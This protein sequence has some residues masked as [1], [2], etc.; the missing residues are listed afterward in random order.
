MKNKF[1]RAVTAVAL[2]VIMLCTSAPVYAQTDAAQVAAGKVCRIGDV[3][4]STI[5]EAVSAVEKNGTATIT[6]IANDKIETGKEDGS[7]THLKIEKACNITIEGNNHTLTFENGGIIPTVTGVTLTVNNLNIH[8]EFKTGIQSMVQGRNGATLT[9]NNCNFTSASDAGKWVVEK[10]GKP[11]DYKLFQINNSGAKATNMIFNGGSI[12]CALTHTSSSN[13]WLMMFRDATQKGSV[14]F[15]SVTFDLKDNISGI[16]GMGP[17]AVTAI[18]GTTALSVKGI[19]MGACSGGQFHIADTA[20]FKSETGL[21]RSDVAGMDIIVT[22]AAE[23]AFGDYTAPVMKDGATLRVDGKSYGLRF[24]SEM[25]AS[26]ISGASVSY[27]TVVTKKSTLD[28]LEGCYDH[29]FFAANIIGHEDFINIKAENGI[30]T[31]DNKATFNAALVDIKAENVNAAM[32]GRAY[33]K[34]TYSTSMMNVY[35]YSKLDTEK[36]S[37]VY[38]DVVLAALADV[39][40]TA[41]SEYTTAVEAYPVLENGAYKWTNATVY[42]RYGSKQYSELKAVAE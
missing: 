36:N 8:D 29:W 25:V 6:M 28:A 35:V 31:A 3:Y 9:F 20:S 34:Y 40:T 30:T 18:T 21:M 11:Q 33:A 12:S 4:Y 7:N 17:N 13:I 23:S 27:G 39:K 2:A 5:E 19:G 32:V 16:Y 42:T 1:F 14:E 24:T 15:R 37:A 38:R 10:D 22:S 41:D 26:N